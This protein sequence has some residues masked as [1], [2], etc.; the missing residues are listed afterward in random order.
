M[1]LTTEGGSGAAFTTDCVLSDYAAATGFDPHAGPPGSNPTDRGCAIRD[2]LKYRA[3]TGILD[4]SGR[5]HR[6]GAFMRLDQSD[7]A[8]VYQALYLFQ[9]VGVGLHFPD[10][11]R[12][13]FHAGE[14]WDVVPGATV[15]GGHYVTMVARRD[16]IGIITWGQLVQITEAFFTEYCEE[17]WA[18]ISQ[19]DLHN[20]VSPQGFDL[21]AL[22]SDLDAL[23]S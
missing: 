4:D 18:Y 16:H 5:R 22:Q 15:E 10:S 13:Q 19:E 8:Q 3:R 1:L 23:S 20:G 21:T 2:V 17:A 6:I 9:V 14:V 7:L 12:A 11:A